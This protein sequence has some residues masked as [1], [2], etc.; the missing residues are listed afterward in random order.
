MDTSSSPEPP[1]EHDS[2][3]Y[4]KEVLKT[5][6]HPSPS[7]SRTIQMDALT[8]VQEENVLDESAANQVAARHFY[9]FIKIFISERLIRADCTSGSSEV[10][11]FHR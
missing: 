1:D 10:R 6:N 7:T 3:I 4:P 8:S 9:F 2:K 5:E 11:Y